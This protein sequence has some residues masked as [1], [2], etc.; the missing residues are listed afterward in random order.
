[1]LETITMITSNNEDNMRL[2]PQFVN[3]REISRGEAQCNEC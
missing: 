1:M 3:M 2:K